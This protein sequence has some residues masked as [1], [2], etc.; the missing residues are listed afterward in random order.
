MYNLYH[1]LVSHSDSVGLVG[2]GILLWAYFLLSAGR[3]SSH[4]L[5]YQLMNFAGAWLILFSLFFHW[6]LS[7]VVIEIAWLLI[8]AMGIVRCLWLKRKLRLQE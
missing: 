1:L 3:L 8:S 6:N 2:V 4:A 5:S 7:S